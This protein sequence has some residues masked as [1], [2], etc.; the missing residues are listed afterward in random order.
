MYDYL[1]NNRV[2]RHHPELKGFCNYD[3]SFIA[4]RS[5]EHYY[6]NT[7]NLTSAV[8]VRHM[9]YTNFTYVSYFLPA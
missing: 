6:Y 3:I 9:P 2:S 4:G 8:N 7:L 1:A 5:D